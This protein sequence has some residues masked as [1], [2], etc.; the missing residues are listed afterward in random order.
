MVVHACEEQG[1]DMQLQHEFAGENKCSEFLGVNS[2]RSMP[3]SVVGRSERGPVST[4]NTSD[5]HCARETRSPPAICASSK[6]R[7]LRPCPPGRPV[8]PT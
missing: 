7:A 1:A 6:P 2:L 4:K 3:T 8:I 5:A